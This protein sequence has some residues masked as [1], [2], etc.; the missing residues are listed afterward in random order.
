MRKITFIYKNDIKRQLLFTYCETMEVACKM[1]T[2]DLYDSER[3]LI[4]KTIARGERVPA[5]AFRLVVGICIFNSRGEMLIQRRQPFKKDWSGLWDISVGGAVIAGESSREAAEREV[6]EELGLEISLENVPPKFSFGF[7]RVLCDFYVVNMDVDLSA[8]TLQYEEVA[9]V[10][11]ASGEKIHKM[12]ENKEFITYE[13]SIID[14][15][16]Y[17][18]KNSDTRVA[19]DFTTPIPR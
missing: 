6:A 2:L 8:L 7:E 1:E 14:M 12:I 13:R 17:L 19:E 10:A 16:F 9:D 18:S 3:R 4:G 11:W 5:G 15:I